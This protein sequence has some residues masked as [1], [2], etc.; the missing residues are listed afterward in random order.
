MMAPMGLAEVVHRETKEHSRD[1][2][3]KANGGQEAC[4]RGSKVTSEPDRE[5]DPG[6]QHRE[7]KDYEAAGG[8]RVGEDQVGRKKVTQSLDL[9]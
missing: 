6:H 4:S 3:G 1:S 2:S 9:Y 7:E 8:E 5:M